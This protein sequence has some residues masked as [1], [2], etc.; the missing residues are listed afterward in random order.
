MFCF[1]TDFTLDESVFHRKPRLV[2]GMGWGRS[3]AN[4]LIP[5]E[6]VYSLSGVR[7]VA[8]FGRIY[9]VP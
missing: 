5:F 9:F 1:G 7:T 4:G 2:A 8:S 3:L 6:G